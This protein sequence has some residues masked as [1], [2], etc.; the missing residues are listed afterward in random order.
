MEKTICS[1]KPDLPLSEIGKTSLELTFN[2]NPYV[3]LCPEPR[4]S[5]VSNGRISLTLAKLIL[6]WSLDISLDIVKFNK[7]S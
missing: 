2:E 1:R 5:L 6:V 7:Q 3:T 4:S